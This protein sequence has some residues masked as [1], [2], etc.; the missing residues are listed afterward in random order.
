M[1]R[2]TVNLKFVWDDSPFIE[3]LT[4]LAVDA[5]IG[6]TDQEVNE[7]EVVRVLA[8]HEIN[9]PP[10]EVTTALRNLVGREVLSGTDSY[11]FSVQ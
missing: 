1:E 3:Q 2:A 11:R 4:L 5:A 6:D 7:K 8:T 10:G 9:L